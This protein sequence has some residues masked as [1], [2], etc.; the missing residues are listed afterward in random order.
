MEK[1]GL[2]K[3]DSMTLLRRVANAIQQIE[4]KNS[5]YLNIIYIYNYIYIIYIYVQVNQQNFSPSRGVGILFFATRT[6]TGSPC[7]Y[8]FYMQESTMS[9]RIAGVLRC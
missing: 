4:S 1:V 2:V 3:E 8:N 6:M 5:V 9:F 7:S